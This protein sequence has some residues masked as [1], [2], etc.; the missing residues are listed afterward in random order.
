MR[1]YDPGQVA[2]IAGPFNVQGFADGTFVTVEKDE[3]AFTLQMG[4]DGE[5]TRSKSNNDSGTITIS[6]MQSSP[7][8]ADLSSLHQADLLNGGGIFPLMIK[9]GSG[10]SL[11]SAEQAFIAKFPSAE[12]GREA[13][14]REWVIKTD[15][16]IVFEGGNS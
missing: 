6:L 10:N 7:S 9:D 11:Y 12:F 14:P 3:D 5:G 13:G 8:N 4:T 16:L 15:K 2:I 1:T